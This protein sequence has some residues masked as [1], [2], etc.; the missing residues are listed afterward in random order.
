MSTSFQYIIDAGGMSKFGEKGSKMEILL[1]V[2]SPPSSYSRSPAP[3]VALTLTPPPMFLLPLPDLPL[4][5]SSFP[6]LF[7]T[8]FPGIDSNKT[9]PYLGGNYQNCKFDKSKIVAKM[10]AYVNITSG[11]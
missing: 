2:A 5:P 11:K 6:L 7:L 9:Y 3:T 10:S 1:P 4:L 8:P